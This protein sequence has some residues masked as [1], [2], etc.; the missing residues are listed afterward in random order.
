MKHKYR[1]A[2]VLKPGFNFLPLRPHVERVI[3]ATDGIIFNVQDVALQLAES[4]Y[5][6]DPE[7]DCI[8]PVGTAV[9]NVVAGLI[10]GS[11]YP[12]SPI[13]LAIYHGRAEEKPEHYT[14]HRV[15][16]SEP[17]ELPEGEMYGNH[18]IR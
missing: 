15:S 13:T 5:Q 14:F 9:V 11:R 3:Y 7:L 17:R 4:L 1:N 10:L 12:D 18:R 2:F 8:V 16:L 6:F